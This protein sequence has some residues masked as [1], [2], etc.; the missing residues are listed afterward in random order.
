M[1]FIAV[2][3][4]GGRAMNVLFPVSMYVGAVVVLT[5]AG[6]IAVSLLS[7]P[8]ASNVTI[9]SGAVEETIATGQKP[10]IVVRA[11]GTAFRYGPE[12]NHGRGDTPTYARDA[13]VARSQSDGAAEPAQPNPSGAGGAT[14]HSHH[15][16]FA[17]TV[18]RALIEGQTAFANGPMFDQEGARRKR[19]AFRR[20]SQVV[21]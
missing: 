5:S 12:V 14:L 1:T 4:R 18:I 15:H 16:V 10:Q 7:S 11:D 2:G 6:V 3:I 20:R 9:A 17:W 8:S 13:S 21:R 19:N